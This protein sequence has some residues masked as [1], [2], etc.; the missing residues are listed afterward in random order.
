[1]ARVVPG[2][3][4]V[5]VWGDKLRVLQRL[6]NRMQLVGDPAMLR[7]R[8]RLRRRR[9]WLWMWMTAVA[10]VAQVGILMRAMAGVVVL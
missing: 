4:V 9:W 2:N 1:M 3:R 8:M 6:V 10:R 7:I 5:V